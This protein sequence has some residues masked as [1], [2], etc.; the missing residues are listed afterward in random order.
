MSIVWKMAS[1][2]L[3]APKKECFYKTSKQRMTELGGGGGRIKR[4]IH[5]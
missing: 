1:S 3:C 2:K 4:I 5:T